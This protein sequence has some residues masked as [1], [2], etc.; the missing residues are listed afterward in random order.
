[1][2]LVDWAFLQNVRELSNGQIAGDVIPLPLVF[3]RDAPGQPIGVPKAWF[4]LYL[5]DGDP[6]RFGITITLTNPSGDSQLVGK[7]DTFE[8]PDGDSAYTAAIYFD[9]LVVDN[10]DKN[11]LYVFKF[12]GSGGQS[13]GEVHVPFRLAD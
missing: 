11:G 12:L 5:E 8:W 1:M 2:R 9:P 6:G 4:I 10:F 3:P 13:I 7:R